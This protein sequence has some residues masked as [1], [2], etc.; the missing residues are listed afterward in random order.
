MRAVVAALVLAML[1]ACDGQG[2]ATTGAAAPELAVLDLDGRVVKLADYRGQV[3]LLNF[4]ISG[5]GPCL[6]E[7]PVLEAAYRDHQAEG[8]EVLGINGGQDVETVVA[9]RRREPV[10]YPLLSDR[11]A[12]TSRTYNVVGFP[13][14]FLIDRQGNL[15]ERIDGPL[16]RE[17]LEQKLAALR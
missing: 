6:A 16:T 4:W 11:L 5:C 1:T 9:T 8:F 15:H 3:V 14:S 7:L 13:V 12:I 2:S 17:E 10:S